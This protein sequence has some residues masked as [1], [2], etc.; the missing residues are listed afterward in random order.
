M[1]FS[2]D[3]A[4]ETP[5]P[6]MV[7]PPFNIY[8]GDKSQLERNEILE[9]HCMLLN[10]KYNFVSCT[11]DSCGSILT[12]HWKDHLSN[13]HGTCKHVT[14]S[15]TNGVHDHEVI[16]EIISANSVKLTSIDEPLQ[17]LPVYE[18]YM[19]SKCLKISRCHETFKR[20]AC[21]L[22]KD[23]TPSISR[24]SS[25]VNYQ[26]INGSHFKVDLI[27]RSNGLDDDDNNTKDSL[28]RRIDEILDSSQKYLD[29]LSLSE[30]DGKNVPRFF[31]LAG[32]T[33]A[34][35]GKEIESDLFESLNDK[36]NAT[37]IK[38]CHQIFKNAKD[39]IL[40][41][42][43]LNY[44]IR[45]EIKSIGS[46]SSNMPFAPL[47]EKT[48][49]KYSKTLVMFITFIINT[50]NCENLKFEQPKEI[51]LEGIE[52]YL[53]KIICTDPLNKKE[54]FEKDDEMNFFLHCLARKNNKYASMEQIGHW[55]VH[56]IYAIRASVYNKCLENFDLLKSITP[57]LKKDSFTPFSNLI[58]LR[59][60][61]NSCSEG[62]FKQPTMLWANDKFN[63]IIVKGEVISLDTLSNVAN[64]ILIDIK[65][66][67]CQITN[68]PQIED[69]GKNLLESLQS[70]EDY[71]SNIF[72]IPLTKIKKLLPLFPF[73]HY[74]DSTNPQI[75]YNR[76]K[77][78][79][80]AERLQDL[81][82]AAMHLTCG[83]PARGT[84]ISELE[85]CG[86]FRCLFVTRGK[87]CLYFRYTKTQNLRG[88]STPIIKFLSSFLSVYFISYICLI[89]PLEMSLKELSLEKL[90]IGK[91]FLFWKGGEKQSGEQLRKS[92]ESSF[93]GLGLKIGFQDYRHLV[94]AFMWH[95]L[96]ESVE[97]EVD[98][99]SQ[100]NHGAKAA[101]RYGKTTNDSSSFMELER[102]FHVVSCRWQKYYF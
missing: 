35:L 9:K 36:A 72:A 45:Q 91:R 23:A 98:I 37:L 65:L 87:L 89:R 14:E 66:L 57:F 30:T 51:S 88:Y 77:F 50:N 44:Q 13:I 86:N 83:A 21:K 59:N 73:S 10:K 84:E 7:G 38:V 32:W 52:D 27:D 76:T 56:L 93:R 60:L 4:R 78:L 25:V 28:D 71:K 64:R 79:Q 69:I 6:D 1:S 33:K 75:A 40:K 81:L 12:R 18:G 22:E 5:I 11:L 46:E 42:G 15:K 67:M 74:F 92:I 63:D 20:H 102:K 41:G 34:P 39:N 8:F 54:N 68:S 49:A 43:R 53:V 58:N 16:D 80:K 26:I 55:I 85:Y 95:H 70:I 29:I 48:F 61:S 96:S 101:E 17:G 82:L 19:C 94:K 90:S 97:F 2:S 3:G 62:E 31:T 99:H 100:F 24:S 47:E